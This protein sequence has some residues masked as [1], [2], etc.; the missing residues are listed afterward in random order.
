MAASILWRAGDVEINCAVGNLSS[1]KEKEIPT[2]KA[3]L[4]QQP[5]LT[6]TA[7]NV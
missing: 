2:W 6:G 7:D 3:S 1:L 5:R 4:S